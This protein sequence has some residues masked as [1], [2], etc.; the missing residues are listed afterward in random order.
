MTSIVFVS[1]APSDRKFRA[2][3]ALLEGAL[4]P[5][6]GFGIEAL[7][8]DTHEYQP[9]YDKVTAAGSCV[10]YWFE[11]SP[12]EV[13]EKLALDTMNSRAAYLA[14]Q[15]TARRVTDT[16]NRIQTREI[17]NLSA[18][19]QNDRQQQSLQKL[20]SEIEN[21]IAGLKGLDKW[22]EVYDQRL[23]DKRQFLA[24]AAPGEISHAF[25]KAVYDEDVAAAK[26]SFARA[27]GEF[28]TEGERAVRGAEDAL[29]SWEAAAL[30]DCNAAREWRRPPVAEAFSIAYSAAQ[31][32]AR[33]EGDLKNEKRNVWISAALTASVCIVA[34]LV[35]LG[36]VNHFSGQR[37]E[38]LT[39]RNDRMQSELATR[40]QAESR[41]GAEVVT[42]LLGCWA[43]A[44]RRYRH[45]CAQAIEISQDDDEIVVRCNYEQARTPLSYTVTDRSVRLADQQVFYRTGETLWALGG[46]NRS[47]A[48]PFQRIGNVGSPACAIPS[49]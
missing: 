24:R 14:V 10:V 44:D 17:I 25:Y 2:L 3:Y 1:E 16:H 46:R 33:A 37:I 49:R 13:I 30:A 32:R 38:E 26:A 19:D 5:L 18:W 36:L 6:E 47:N 12:G 7:D 23:E 43:I 9:K 42:S 4:A 28:E 35:G 45:E 41:E 48:A 27:L 39:R 29:R 34:A 20:I 22:I 21:A 8:L 15:T 31:E 40:Q 11:P